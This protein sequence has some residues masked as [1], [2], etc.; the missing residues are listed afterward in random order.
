MA[1]PQANGWTLEPVEDPQTKALLDYSKG[2]PE[3]PTYS[4]SVLPFS[5]YT[6]GSVRFD[7]DAGVLGSLKR[8]MTLPGDVAL[9]KVDPLSQ[10]A[11]G[12][13]ADLGFNA[14]G[15][16]AGAAGR[17]APEASQLGMFLG[18]KA[19]MANL[20]KL[21]RA[22]ELAAQGSKPEDTLLKTG[23]FQGADGQWRFEIP[24]HTVSSQEAG[25]GAR[26]PI[27]DVVSHPALYSNYPE[28]KQWNVTGIPKGG[29][30]GF[31]NSSDQLIGA[32]MGRG[33]ALRT[34]T[35]L[36]ELQH[37]VQQIEGWAPGANPQAFTLAQPGLDEASSWDMYN[38]AAGE[39]E[40]RNTQKRQS[41]SAAQRA[42][43]PPWRTQSVP[44]ARQLVPDQTGG[45]S[46]V[47]VKED[48][49]DVK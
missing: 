3:V 49:F 7:S 25:L 6:D 16:G 36:H 17:A 43:V 38:R 28:I 9:G 8:G 18:P 45:W 12:R 15:V 41:M 42:V 19:K 37:V 5:R 1:A 2:L 48:P 33:D 39:V 13:A 46:L 35:H 26:T 10:E 20:G 11:I 34:S 31:M 32:Q 22:Q 30:F 4:G 47:P 29:P 44:D 21:Q 14:L 24:D 27:A 23:W 40:A